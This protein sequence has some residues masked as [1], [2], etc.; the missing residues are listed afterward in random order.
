M[1]TDDG[2]MLGSLEKGV[3]LFVQ[4]NATATMSTGSGNTAATYTG[5]QLA[6]TPAHVGYKPPSGATLGSVRILGVPLASVGS[7]TVA[8]AS[9]APPFTFNATTQVLTV[10]G[11]AA[12]LYEA[13]SITWS[14]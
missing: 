7:V 5:G 4:F 10:S 3:F 8:G 11:L 12:P 2:D 13:F 14:S 1:F 9:S 6:G